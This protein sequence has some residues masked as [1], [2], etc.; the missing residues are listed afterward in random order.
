MP[1]RIVP[2]RWVT[3]DVKW[4]LIEEATVIGGSSFVK[5]E[6]EG[7]PTDEIEKKRSNRHYGWEPAAVVDPGK[8]WEVKEI[9]DRKI[10]DG[11]IS[12]YI[13]YLGFTEE[14]A[15]WIKV[16]GLDCQWL[17]DKY[18]RRPINLNKT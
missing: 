2:N 3:G 4:P 6:R 17:V 11:N 15:E 14:W 9:L 10:E 8:L 16:E 12:Y 1:N 5:C 7:E 13:S 18:N